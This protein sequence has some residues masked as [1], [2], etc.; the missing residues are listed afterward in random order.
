MRSY[1][2]EVGITR[3]AG[4][5]E[6]WTTRTAGLCRRRHTPYVVPVGYLYDGDYVYIHSLPG[7]KINALRAN[8]R[9]CLQV[10]EVQDEF[11]WKSVIAFGSYEE[12]ED[13]AERARALD[14]LSARFPRL[15][16]VE[17][18]MAQSEKGAKPIIF[19]PRVKMITGLAEK[20]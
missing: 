17:S 8:P 14:K 11:N 6:A 10:D 12:I 7:R 5:V 1:G 19:R 15:T 20:V 2:G 9:A 4:F 16:P 18:V 3:G 13:P